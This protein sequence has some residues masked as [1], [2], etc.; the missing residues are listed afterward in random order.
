MSPIRKSSSPRLAASPSGARPPASRRSFIKKSRDG[1]GWRRRQ[2]SVSN[3][4]RQNTTSHVILY[5][6]NGCRGSG[7]GFISP[8][9][10]SEVIPAKRPRFMPCHLERGEHDHGKNDQQPTGHG[11][12]ESLIARTPRLGRTA[13]T[14]DIGFGRCLVSGALKVEFGRAEHRVSDVPKF[15]IHRVVEQ[16]VGGLPQV[17]EPSRPP[18]SG[19]VPDHP[20]DRGQMHKAPAPES[21]LQVNQFLAQLVE[22]GFELAVLVHV[23]PRINTDSFL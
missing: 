22:L 6:L 11:E 12:A 14:S 4:T 3:D 5:E 16:L 1:S 15:R 7:G 13:S 23:S 8:V 17:A 19:T 10:A 20:G 2:A 9:L 18:G 21:V